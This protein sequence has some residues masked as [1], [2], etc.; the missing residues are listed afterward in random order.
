[1]YWLQHYV[2]DW[3]KVETIEDIKKIL[4]ALQIS[5][6]QDCSGLADIKDL[7][8]LVDKNEQTITYD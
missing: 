4:T 6:E 5:F 1:M 7:I 8:K 2:V 3:D